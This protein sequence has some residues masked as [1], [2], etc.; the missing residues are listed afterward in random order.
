MSKFW[1][2]LL[3]VGVVVALAV[4]LLWGGGRRVSGGFTVVTTFHPLTVLAEPVI[5]D[6]A[7]VAQLIPSGQGAHDFQ[8]SPRD[9]QRIQQADLLV[10]NGAGLEQEWLEPL[11]EAAGR[12]DNL[13]TLDMS[14]AVG[15]VRPLI[16][17]GDEHAE[18][19]SG[20]DEAFELDPHI[21]LSPKNAVVMVEAL[22]DKVATLDQ[23][24]AGTYRV[25][26]ATMLANLVAL[27]TEITNSTNA[28]ARREFVAFHNAFS[29]FAR[30]YELQQVGVIELT[31]GEDPTP[32]QVAEL[33]TLSQSYGLTALYSEPQYSSA[34]V[35]QLASD[36]GLE[37]LV[38]DPLETAE[39]R[40]GYIEAMRR[41]LQA[42]KEGQGASGQ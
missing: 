16:S 41:N 32:G 34:L 5:G 7:T 23:A 27:D 22:R 37:V 1:I 21:W 20:Q 30:D 17:G 42:L 36:L 3:G 29:Y 9:I 14:V 31:P 26:A 35:D 33:R 11:L 8:P 2:V 25:N 19:G 15:E 13:P 39:G 40:E 18:E 28:F 38:L 24:H 12:R 4:A 6:A 10:F